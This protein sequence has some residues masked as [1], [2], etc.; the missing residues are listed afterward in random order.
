MRSVLARV[1]KLGIYFGPLYFS[2][3]DG[4]CIEAHVKFQLDLSTEFRERVKDSSEH[5]DVV[6]GV[7]V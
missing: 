6:L 3:V 1:E 5:G 7:S 2:I 4:M